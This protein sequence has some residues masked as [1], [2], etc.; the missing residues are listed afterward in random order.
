MRRIHTMKLLPLV[1]ALGFSQPG[2]ASEAD[3]REFE[4]TLHAPYSAVAAAQE[5]R[6]FSLQFS[7]PFIEQ[8]HD[9]AWRLELVDAA[10]R[11]IER[12]Q[13]SERLSGK[14]VDVKVKWG[15]RA[16]DP[17]LRD[18]VY[19]VR[20]VAV[21]NDSEG[22]G[23]RALSA[24]DIE[25]MIDGDGG[26]RVEQSWD[27]VVGDAGAVPMPAFQA[28]P[29]RES[30]KADKGTV[31]MM[32]APAPASL[33]YT[34][35]YANLHSQTNHSDGGGALA[36]CTSSESPQ[37]GA[38]GPTDAFAYAKG[39]GLDILMASEHNHM[40]D[41]SSSTNT[42]ASP[43]TAKALY[44]SGLKS[45]SDFN[46][47][48]PGFLAVY[49]LEWGVI[50]NGGHLNVLNSN[51]LIQWEY[52]ASNQLLGDT[53]TAKSDYATLYSLMKSRG[54][55]G[56]FNHPES[57][58]QF[59]VGGTPLGYSADGDEAMVLCEVMNT[60]AFST[61]TTETETSRS[62]YESACKKAL[63]AGYHVAFS[64]NQDNHCANW[65]ASYTNRTGVLIPTGTAL[66]QAS[67][68]DALR[69]RR[70][71]ATMD[72]TSQLV[73]TANGRLM[74]ERFSNSGPL[75][76]VT[77][78]ANSSGKTVSTVAIFEGVPKRNGTVTQ[79]STSANTTITPSV[80]EH[81]YYA[82]ITQSDGKIL[83]SAP[84]WV[85]QVAASSDTTAPTVSAVETGASGTITLSATASDN[86]GVS[87]V[88][89][90]VDNVLKGTDS[91]APY[92]MTLDSTTLANGCHTLT[93][94]AYD[95]AGNVGNAS[96]VS[97]SITNGTGTG[98]QLLA[99]PG[100]ESGAVSWSGGSGIVNNVT[101]TAAR[102]GSWKAKFAGTGATRTDNLYQQIAIPSTAASVT[103][104]FWLQVTTAE[105][106]TSTAYDTLKL[107][108]RNSGGTIL[109]TPLSYSNLNKGTGY[110]QRSVD[111]SA[112]KGQTVQIFFAGAEDSSLQTTFLVDDV[113]L[114]VQ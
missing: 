49:G 48:N 103:L 98:T 50:S 40:Y 52:N 102:T 2:I 64:T 73:L 6:M 28:M 42:S 20:M 15:G 109:A 80:G 70:V 47:A 55:I 27:I 95:A 31:T 59:L 66:T 26:H 44:Q 76:L 63:E 36:S 8:D 101:T 92:S 37:A 82:K 62:T 41:G 33:P 10:Q 24:E 38:F 43:A 19:Q 114:T 68:V 86:V 89:F 72:K 78:F 104:S 5:G 113:A 112:Y 108:V 77:N 65:G 61:N 17:A 39:K 25:A 53:Y 83:W 11:V 88:E 67:F 81:F 97:F 71:F 84:V 54:W 99:N 106:T 93:A 23:K 45:A 4:A 57:T 30:A 18:G 13:G 12:W 100:F 105:T 46:L 56:Q 74:G 34:V 87:R 111:L 32:S 16:T 69:A 91:A 107:Q 35:Y 85:T 22:R 110:V 60:S 58:G 7:Y 3:H 75:N 96:A 51:E 9:V 1:L 94:K 21:A 90:Y 14:P 29:S 79:L